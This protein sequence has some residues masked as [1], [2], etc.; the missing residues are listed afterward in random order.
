MPN[1]TP[2][3]QVSD[4][5]LPTTLAAVLRYAVTNLCTALVASGYLPADQVEG[6][7]TLILAVATFL[8]GLY[9]T[10]QNRAALI[11]TAEAAPD[12]VAQVT[13]SPLS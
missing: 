1:P 8:Y 6:V 3:I 9:K 13:P 5:T 4:S 10:R 2:P 7:L 12:R 11:T